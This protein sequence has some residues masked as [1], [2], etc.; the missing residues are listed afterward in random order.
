MKVLAIEHHK[1]LVLIHLKIQDR[2][3]KLK[4]MIDSSADVNMLYK[5]LILAKY[6]RKTSHTIIGVGNTQ[7]S[8]GYEIPKATLCFEQHCLD[9]KFFLSEIPVACILGTPFL[10]VVEPYGSAR[11]SE[12]K[13]AFFIT[14]P[15]IEIRQGSTKAI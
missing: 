5:D 4:A 1:P 13:V 6:W 8:L 14:L 9:M 15:N 12:G 7:V 3:F 10:A 11:T 2:V